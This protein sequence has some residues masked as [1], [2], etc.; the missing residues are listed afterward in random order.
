MNRDDVL[1]M[2]SEAGMILV[3]NEWLERFAALVAAH[4]REECAR[5]CEAFDGIWGDDEV[6]LK[7]AAAIR[8]RGES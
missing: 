6:C 3:T 7:C 8:T 1:K 5:V 2:A 4:E